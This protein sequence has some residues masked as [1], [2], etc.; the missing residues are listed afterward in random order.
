[1]TKTTTGQDKILAKLGIEKLKPMQ[2]EALLAIESMSD[3]IL[4]SPTGSGKTLAFLLPIISQLDPECKEIQVMILV[5]S[6]EL[7]MQVEQVVRSMGTGF[8][9]NAV[10][11]GRAGAE[12]KKD[13]KHFIST[14]NMPTRKVENTPKVR[15]CMW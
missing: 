1:M 15:E 13:L 14:L 4:L 3:I 12:D 9:A 8:K 7:A 10:Y 2:E 5:P 11:G 6:R